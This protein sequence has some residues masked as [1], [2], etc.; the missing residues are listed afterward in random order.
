[1]RKATLTVQDD[2]YIEVRFDTPI[3]V[4]RT[5][6]LVSGHRRSNVWITNEKGR[7]IGFKLHPREFADIGWRKVRNYFKKG[8]TAK[9]TLK[10]N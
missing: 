5:D 7:V 9:V 3:N 2:A 8:A 1:M 6:A 10:E 4:T